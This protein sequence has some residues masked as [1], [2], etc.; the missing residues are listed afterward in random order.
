M[1]A[2]Q[3]LQATQASLSDV[4]NMISTGLRVSTAKDDAATWV[5]STTMKA[6]IA[7]LTQVGQSLGNAQSVLATAASGAN[8]IATLIGKIRA[9]VTSTQDPS[10]DVTATQNQVDQ[11]VNQINAIVTS[12]NFD[13]VN[14]LDGTNAAG[15]QFLASTAGDYTRV[16]AASTTIST[17]TTSNLSAATA[18]GAA[19]MQALFNLVDSV[20]SGGGLAAITGLTIDANMKTIDAAAATVKAAAAQFGAVQS[21]IEGQ[22]A[23]VKSLTS[24]L[25]T[26]VGNM[27]DADMTAESAR[28][29]ALQ[30]QQQLG[31]QALSIANQAPQ[32]LLKLFG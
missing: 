11:L 1:V 14:L 16:G 15:V 4:Q 10:T 30:V 3:S 25:Q 31:T 17:G 24:T 9:A 6:N 18:T 8:N 2:L 32:L 29:S 26:G 13:G 23:F 22:Q 19:T 5:V 28:L 27:V 20:G 7:S 12:S 21:N